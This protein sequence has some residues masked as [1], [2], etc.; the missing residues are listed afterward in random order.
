M[1]TL[2]L[3]PVVASIVL[4]VAAA[5]LFTPQSSAYEGNL[6]NLPPLVETSWEQ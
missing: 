3:A 6:Q 5:A 2:K 4:G 1:K